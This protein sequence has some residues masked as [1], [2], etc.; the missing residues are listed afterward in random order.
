MFTTTGGCATVEI[1]NPRRFAATIVISVRP[2]PDNY[3]DG[4]P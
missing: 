3:L 1:V 2:G 4:H